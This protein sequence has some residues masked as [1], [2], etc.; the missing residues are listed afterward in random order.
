MDARAL[1]YKIA[2]D[3]SDPPLFAE[4]WNNFKN[5]LI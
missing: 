1:E 5:A 4:N 3:V 2:P